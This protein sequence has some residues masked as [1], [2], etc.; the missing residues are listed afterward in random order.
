MQISG[1]QV[2]LLCG[3]ISFPLHVSRWKQI[4]KFVT[5]I[6]ITEIIV[7]INYMLQ[8]AQTQTV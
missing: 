4:E 3:G 6:K 2:L 7:K 8:G 5:N 1:I